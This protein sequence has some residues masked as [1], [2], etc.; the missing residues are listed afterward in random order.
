[1]VSK[2]YQCSGDGEE[3]SRA[4]S[5]VTSVS[6]KPATQKVVG[7]YEYNAA[8][9]AKEHGCET[10]SLLTQN[11]PVEMYQIACSGSHYVIKCEWNNCIVIK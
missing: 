9:L 5:T 1:M 4:T 6:T 2:E 8:V 3:L 10:P 11:P 7:K